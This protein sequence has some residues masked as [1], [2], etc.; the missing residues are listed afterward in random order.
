MMVVVVV[1]GVVGVVG[2]VVVVVVAA[3]APFIHRDS[4]F[5]LVRV[6]R[7][8]GGILMFEVADID[9]SYG[10]NSLKGFI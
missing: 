4:N 10:L 9:M 1:V 6:G 3:A 5:I 7:V 2:V 8:G